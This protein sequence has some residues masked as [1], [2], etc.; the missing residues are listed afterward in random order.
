MKALAL[1]ALIAGCTEPATVAVSAP[2]APPPIA[3]EPTELAPLPSNDA[4]AH[5]ALEAALAR[6]A[7]TDVTSEP[8]APPPDEGIWTLRRGRRVLAEGPM[9]H[10]LRDGR[11]TRYDEEGTRIEEGSYRADVPVGRWRRWDTDGTRLEDIVYDETACS[12]PPD[13]ESLERPMICGT[14][15]L[16]GF[17]HPPDPNRLESYGVGEVRRCVGRAEPWIEAGISTS[18]S[19]PWD[20]LLNA[21][22]SPELQALVW[23]RVLAGVED[24]HDELQWFAR[25][26]ASGTP[27]ERAWL[28]ELALQRPDRLASLAHLTMRERLRASPGFAARTYL[29]A[30]RRAL[31]GEPARLSLLTSFAIEALATTE[32]ALRLS[33]TSDAATFLHDFNLEARLS[34]VRADA[35][36]D[37]GRLDAARAEVD[38]AELGFTLGRHAVPFP[39]IADLRARLSGT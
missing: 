33:L 34:L 22:H 27:E 25:Q 10:G 30:R 26:A 32:P 12:Q 24:E 11:W 38:R 4:E 37:E 18:R 3:D 17:V 8:P 19:T 39:R 23:R 29:E 7:A 1:L 16:R 36:L 5:E 35:C 2:I 15:M 31:A 28:A 21:A 9:H 14:A 6:L 20:E 13:R